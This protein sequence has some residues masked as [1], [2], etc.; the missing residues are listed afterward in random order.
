MTFRVVEKPVADRNVYF[1]ES[2]Q[3]LLSNLLLSHVS[4]QVVPGTSTMEAP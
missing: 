3:T 1:C 2:C 4:S